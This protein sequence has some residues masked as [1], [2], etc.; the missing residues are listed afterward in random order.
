MAQKL[1]DEERARK[2]AESDKEKADASAIGHQARFPFRKA[3]ATL[4]RASQVPLPKD[5]ESGLE[6]KPNTLF[7]GVGP[8]CSPISLWL[9]LCLT[10][11]HNFTIGGNVCSRTMAAGQTWAQKGHTLQQV[12]SEFDNDDENNN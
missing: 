7:H 1:R 3:A 4:A 9:I 6:S 2:K 12:A 10:R 5:D 11:G 8:G